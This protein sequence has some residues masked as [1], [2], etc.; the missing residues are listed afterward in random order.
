MPVEG[1]HLKNLITNINNN[2]KEHNITENILTTVYAFFK[3]NITMF[4]FISAYTALYVFYFQI[5]FFRLTRRLF[6]DSH[7]LQV[8]NL[9][10]FLKIYRRNSFLFSFDSIIFL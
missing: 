10:Y 2:N 9:I 7:V 8:T 1:F 4:I 5:S 3:V 6:M